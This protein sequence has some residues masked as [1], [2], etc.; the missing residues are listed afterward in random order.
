MQT[1][2]Y[3]DYTKLLTCIGCHISFIIIRS[4][5]TGQMS[6]WLSSPQIKT[7][8]LILFNNK[9]SIQLI[10]LIN[11]QG[12]SHSHIHCAWYK[13]TNSKFF[14]KTCLTFQSALCLVILFS[15]I[16]MFMHLPYQELAWTGHHIGFMLISYSQTWLNDIQSS[17]TSI[18]P[19]FNHQNHFPNKFGSKRSILALLYDAE[20]LLINHANLC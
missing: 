15:F 20:Y 16:Y 12:P 2:L 10:S 18:K 5:H 6:I 1:Q 19:V 3:T 17:S 14:N 9:G 4:G 11:A 13:L 8:T 7:W